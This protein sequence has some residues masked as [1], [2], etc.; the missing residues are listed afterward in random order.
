LIPN[1]WFRFLFGRAM[2]ELLRSLEEAS[3]TIQTDF[4]SPLAGGQWV[5]D[6]IRLKNQHFECPENGGQS[7]TPLAGVFRLF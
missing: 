1:L 5:T 3:V 4:L 7:L 2:G 6:I